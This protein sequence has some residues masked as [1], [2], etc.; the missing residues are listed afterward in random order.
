MSCEDGKGW[1]ERER[2]RERGGKGRDGERGEE[3]EGKGGGKLLLWLM[4]KI[5]SERYGSTCWRK[6]GG[7]TGREG[8]KEGGVRSGRVIGGRSL[9]EEK[10]KCRENWGEHG[11]RSDQKANTSLLLFLLLLIL[12]FIL[13]RLP[14]LQSTPLILVF[15]DVL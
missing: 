6:D 4:K 2:E 15:E 5:L 1:R 10:M 12:L 8:G 14:S 13:L 11:E 7:V 9:G 3:R